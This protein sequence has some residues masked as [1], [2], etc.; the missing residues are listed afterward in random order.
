VWWCKFVIS[1]TWEVEVA[2]ETLARIYS[3]AKYKTIKNKQGGDVAQGEA[4]L[5]STWR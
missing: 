2:W 3:K 5:S 4:H 1:V